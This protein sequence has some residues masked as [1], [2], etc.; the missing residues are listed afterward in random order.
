MSTSL[1]QPN[2]SKRASKSA[3]TRWTLAILGMIIALT[4]YV[5]IALLGGFIPPLVLI[6]GLPAAIVA[7]LMLVTRWRWTPL[8]ATL[9][10]IY[11]LA[12]STRSIRYDVS[13]PE[14]YIPYAV[15]LLVTTLTLLGIVSGAGAAIENYRGSTAT[16]LRDA[17]SRLPRWF[18]MV[19]SGLAG[20]CLGAL[21][22]GAVPRSAAGATVSPQTLAALP[23]LAAHHIR[24]APTEIRAQAGSLVALRL[25]NHD[26]AGHTFNIDELNVHIVMPPGQPALALFRAGPP[27]TYTF[28]CD[29]PGH[30]DSGMVG[31]LI[32][33]P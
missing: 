33:T 3:L 17:R 6:L 12:L 26:S 23:T 18:Q 1:A 14:A 7:I 29:V 28:Y 2:T 11:L 22:I 21:I 15:T 20:L 24:F 9:Y 16:E 27:G 30:R 31:T 25:E 32:I 10:G 5:Q 13:H 8:L 19:S 4:I